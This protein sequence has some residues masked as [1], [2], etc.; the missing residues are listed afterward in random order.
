M[1]SFGKIIADFKAREEQWLENLTPLT[2]DADLRNALVAW[3]SVKIEFK[4]MADCHETS[5]VAKWK[6]LW[7]QISYDQSGFMAVS[8]LKGQ[9]VGAVVTRLIGLRLI[10][11]DG[12]INNFARDYLQAL[13]MA[14]LTGGKKGRPPK[15]GKTDEKRK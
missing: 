1:V 13:I 9:E 12:S 2:E 8:G 15:D 10:Y 3:K 4:P 6:W 14:K 5:D 7:G 11:P